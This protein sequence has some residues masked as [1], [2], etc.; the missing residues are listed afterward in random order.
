MNTR[1]MSVSSDSSSCSSPP[2]TASELSCP[3]ENGQQKNNVTSQKTS[4][5]ASR[6]KIVSW[7]INGMRTLDMPQ[8]LEQLDC[9]VLAVQETKISRVAIF[10]KNE[11]T[12]V[13]AEDGLCKIESLKNDDA[14]GC[15]P[16]LTED[17]T[18]HVKAA[19][20]DGRTVITQHMVKLPNGTTRPLTVINVYCPRLRNDPEDPTN[21][22]EFKLCF[23]EVLH[24][25]AKKLVQEGSFVLVVGDINIAHR[26]LDQSDITD[27]KKFPVTDFRGILNDFVDE[28]DPT[29]FVD[30]FRKLHPSQQSAFT[31]WCT[32]LNARE[33]NY[34]ARIDYIFA[35]QE[36]AKYL[37]NAEVHPDIMGSDHCP[38]SAT[39]HSLVPVPATNAPSFATNNYPEFSGKQ[40]KLKEFF[41][42]PGKSK[43]ESEGWSQSI[44]NFNDGNRKRSREREKETSSNSQKPKRV[45]TKL[46]MFFNKNSLLPKESNETDSISKTIVENKV[47]ET[48]LNGYQS[49]PTPSNLDAWKKLM[50]PPEA[51]LCEGHKEPCVKRTVKKKGTNFGR[52]FWACSHGEGKAGD[53]N[54]NCKFFQWVRST[55][56][57]PAK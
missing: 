13:K 48:P 25:R 37:D 15:Y 14:V 27:P 16:D 45:Q 30:T 43:F 2:L 34:G 53:P 24:R 52:Q 38:I 12:P 26:L 5:G 46:N 29:G 19:N 57:K 9:S 22:K 28:N 20:I 18:L 17:E 40:K 32:R 31:C 1:R 39:F 4:T 10:C 49:T 33:N 21:N 35:D 23:H 36:L 41:Q 6:F 51:P 8:V 56:S 50:K 44:T 3:L 11:C 54:A 47:P 42:A 7:N 55:T